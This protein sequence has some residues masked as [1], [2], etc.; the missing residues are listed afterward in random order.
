MA[1]KEK[2]VQKETMV[3]KET[4]AQKEKMVHKEILAQMDKQAQMEIMEQEHRNA[5]ESREKE[6]S[7]T[8][9]LGVMTDVLTDPKKLQGLLEL[10]NNPAYKKK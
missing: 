6:Q 4:M 7:N 5:L 8:A 9:M 3:L 2:M 1:Q 10:A